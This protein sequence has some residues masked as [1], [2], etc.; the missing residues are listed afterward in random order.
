MLL[1]AGR[2]LVPLTQ[3]GFPALPRVRVLLAV[4]AQGTED[5]PSF[6]RTGAREQQGPC[7][8]GGDGT[9]CRAVFSDDS[10][11]PAAAALAGALHPPSP[12]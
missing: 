10:F 12:P 2:C 7:G 3:T 9:V 1:S 8:A 4:D 11:P 6:S 5:L